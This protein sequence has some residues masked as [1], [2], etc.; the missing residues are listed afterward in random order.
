MPAAQGVRDPVAA[1]AGF[2]IEEEEEGLDFPT[3]STTRPEPARG[4]G[5]AR[6]DRREGSGPGE[7]TREDEDKDGWD[8]RADSLESNLEYAKELQARTAEDGIDIDLDD[9]RSGVWRGG[10]G[11][12]WQCTCR[13]RRHAGR[14][15]I[16]AR[17]HS[18]V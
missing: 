7:E 17:R 10:G 2:V 9:H 4:P 16:G 6:G 14:A 15:E 5:A 8:L 1:G 13:A 11:P 18:S 3:S 12:S